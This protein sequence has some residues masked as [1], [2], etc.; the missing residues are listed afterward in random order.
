MKKMGIDNV[1]ALWQSILS[2]VDYN[3]SI[4]LSYLALFY[5]NLV[6]LIAQ[7]LPV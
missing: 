1:I 5:T 3:F 7:G 6:K 2:F 4:P